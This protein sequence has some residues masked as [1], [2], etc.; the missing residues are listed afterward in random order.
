VVLLVGKDQALL[1]RVAQRNAS[2]VKI[3]IGFQRVCGRVVSLL[4]LVHFVAPR[5]N[6]RIRSVGANENAREDF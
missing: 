6:S 4:Q 3:D 1:V 2:S 5:Y